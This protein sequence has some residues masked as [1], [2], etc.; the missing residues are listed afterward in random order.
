MIRPTSQQPALIRELPFSAG[1][2]EDCQSS[3]DSA[4]ENGRARGQERPHRSHE[5]DLAEMVCGSEIPEKKIKHLEKFAAAAPN[6]ERQCHRR[7]EKRTDGPGD[8]TRLFP[9][10]KQPDSCAASG[11]ERDDDAG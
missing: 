3:R 8:K 5:V 11:Q 9:R 6:P 2:R 4:E 7:Y 10:E 1:D